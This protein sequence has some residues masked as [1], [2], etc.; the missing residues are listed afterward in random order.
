MSKEACIVTSPT[1]GRRAAGVRRWIQRGALVVALACLPQ[2]VIPAGYD[3]STAAA[4]D[5]RDFPSPPKDKIDKV[6]PFT[7]KKSNAPADKARSAAADTTARLKD[8]RWPEATSASITL[9]ASGTKAVRAGKL[10]ITLKVSAGLG[11]TKNA[12]QAQAAENSASSVAA[13]VELLGH[14]AA[15]KMGLNGVLFTVNPKDQLPGERQLQVSLDYSSFASAYGGSYGSRLKLVQLPACALT[16]PAKAA[17]RSPK[18]LASE[19]STEDQVLTATVPGAAAKT[20]AAGVQPMV[21]AAA[22]AAGSAGGDFSATPLSQ[23][24][25]WDSGGSTGS[26]TWSYPL[27]VPPAT[28]GPEPVVGISYDSSSVDGRTA[29]ENN[30][31]SVVGEGFSIT[32]SYVE[33]KYG[34]C[35]D[36]GQS[37]K[38]DLC[39]KYDNATLVL[40]GKVSEL[41]KAC[42]T[43]TAC[44]ADEKS[45]G[46]S[47]N[48]RLKG[49]DASRVERLTDTT[50]GNGDANGEYWKVTTG[51][52]T[53]YSFGK[54]K[55]E[56]TA[57][58]RV[59]NSVWTAPV[60]GDDTG[61]PC[62]AS[63]FAASYC[64]QAW[65]WNLDYVVDP[66]GNASSYWYA[67]ESN[68]YA[69]DA[70][71]GTGTAYTR[72]G[73]L[74]RIEYGQRTDSLFTKPASQRVSFTYA[75]RC[76]VTDGCTSLTETTKK[77]WPD[78]PF[79]Q[80]CADSKACPLLVSPTFFTRKRLTDVTTSVWK[81]TG[82]GAGTEADFRSVDG[83]HLEQSFPNSG[84]VS[85]PSLWL[86]SIQNT[87]KAGTA[88][89]LPKVTFGGV[90][91][92]NRVDHP[93]DD[94]AP[95]TKWRVRT[96]KSETGSLITVNYSDVQC[97]RGTLMPTSEDKN[98]LRCYPVYWASDGGEPALDWFHKYVVESVFQD[99]PTGGGRT[100][101][102]YNTYGV[103][104]RGAGWGYTDDEGLTKDK[105][106][107]WSQWRGYAK[108]TTT[109]GDASGPRSKKTDL[110]MRGLDGEKEK[111][112]T[113]RDEKTTDS[114]GKV[115]EDSRQYAGFL[116]ESTTYNGDTVVG[117]T[118]NDPWSQ[119][120]ASHAYT[121]GTTE[122][123]F[124]NT[125]TAHKRERQ[126]DGTYRTQSSTTTF[127]TT[128][129]SPISINDA[130][131]DAV[132]GDETC[133]KT[134][135]V[136]NTSAWLINFPSRVESYAVACGTA[137][138]LPEDTLSD[139]TTAYD[140]QPAGTAPTAGDATAVAR[141]KSYTA[142]VPDYQPVA[143]TGYDALGRVASTKDALNRST[144]T[145]YTPD[146]TGYGPVTGSVITD[147]KGYT[148][149]STIDPAWGS[150]TKSVDVNGSTTEYAFD[151]LGRL[152]EVW[153]PDRLRGLGDAASIEYEY[154]VSN[155]DASWVR[156]GTIKA[157]GKTYNSSY[158]IF[159]SLLR[160]RQ[161]Q[162][163][164]P[165]GGRVISETLYDDRGL[166]TISNADVHDETAPA[167][168]LANTLPG[169]VPAST[170]TV[171][172]GAGRVTESI[173][174]VYDQEKWR[175]KTAHL[176]DRVANT[177]ADGGSGTLAIT[178]GRGQ[179]T[180]RREYAGP[181]P[182]G[183]DYT[184]TTYTY[185]PNGQV[186]TMT[187]PDQSVWTYT[188]DLRGRVTEKTDPDSGKTTTS[189][190]D[191]DQVLS[192]T[193]ARNKTVLFDYDVLG[194]TI[195]TWDGIKDNA[196]QL[197]RLTYDT[198]ANG[199]GQPAASVRYVGGVG[200]T[201]S[202]V[203][204][205]QIVKYDSLYRATESKTVLAATDPLV[206]AGAP[207]TYTTNQIFNADGSTQSVRVP[208][209]GG[210]PGET[211]AY[212][213]NALG[214][215][216]SVKGDTDYVRS[217]GYSPLSDVE[218]TL[219]GTSSTAKRMQILNSYEDG[220]RRL[221]NSRSL[222]D[223]NP[224]YTS[225]VDYVYDASG[226]VTSVTDKATS[227]AQCFAYDGHKR[228]TQAWT[229]A[230]S[231][232]CASA[233]AANNLGG[234]A[235][236]WT[237][238]TYNTAGLRDTQTKQAS[239]GNTVT[240]HTYP[241]LSTAGAGQ[242]HTLTSRSTS[243]VTSS[244]TY[245][246]SGNTKT[247]PG[248]KSTQS[249]VWDIE[250]RLAALTEDGK[251]TTYLYSATGDLL[252]RSG[253]TEAVL[254]LGG[255]EVHYD[256]TTKQFTGQRYYSAGSSTAVRT[257]TGLTWK[258]SDHHNTAS[259]VVDA[260]TQK[261][262]RRYTAPF[263][264]T[265]GTKPQAWPDDKAFLGKPQD[266]STQLTHVGARE[267]D[268]DTGRFISVDPIL[269]PD[270]HESLNGYAY[271]NN[272]PV[273]LADPTGLRPDGACG[274]SGT[275]VVGKTKDGDKKY[276][277]WA[278]N[279]GGGWSWG[280]SATNVQ[281]VYSGRQSYTLTVNV[282][283]NRKSGFSGTI[284]LK[285]G[286]K[287]KPQPKI[288]AM[289]T[290]P[291]AGRGIAGD[292]PTAAQADV[293]DCP[294]SDS[295]SKCSFRQSYYRSAMLLQ[296]T[297]GMASGASAAARGKGMRNPGGCT[298]FLAGTL[299]LMADKTV[300]P[301]EKVKVGDKVLASDPES[302]KTH[303]RKITARI[304][305]KKDR[306]YVALTISTPQGLSSLTA[307]SEHP[308]WVE[309]KKLWF[310]AE[311][312]EP[313][314]TLRTASGTTA[315]VASSLH[316]ED[317]K[318]TYNLTVEGVHTYYVLAGQTPVLVH[319]SNCPTASKYEDITSPGAR[320]L[321]KS[322]D[323]GP[324]DFGK[325]LEA[326]GWSRTEKGPNLMYEKDGARYFLR[327]KANSHKGWTADYYNPGSKK[328]DIKI[329]MGED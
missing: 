83:W 119:R 317:R 202:K 65:R 283:Y 118:I 183:D 9:P 135:Y 210:L 314:M 180:E 301:I 177:A 182:E 205:S 312:L 53:Q 77:N 260:T 61:E 277:T 122:A 325:N 102:T 238:W 255:Q 8:T 143:T 155:A 25:S 197:T 281:E 97:V 249:L 63:T 117:T 18:D 157:D 187:G 250:G 280:W 258:V 60:F 62:N 132:S 138:Q 94:I 298:C 42:A 173:F 319:N 156:T 219:L 10:P 12:P 191:A 140:S 26:F 82:T 305:T 126:P 213:H 295:A 310:K 21:F 27:R 79:D 268:T 49:D 113:P 101:E 87:G 329:R 211:V 37:G 287:P 149:T 19:N 163:P 131:D 263:G 35:K 110:F 130:G 253:P 265:R 324:V 228:L 136:R 59:T 108:V 43:D 166:A 105:H 261:L 245:D 125:A 40:N 294:A 76:V 127:D 34:S 289:G 203:Y 206:L 322:T 243:G 174:R 286:P 299:V 11:K 123:W 46:A 309:S 158:E 134:T 201:G 273:T 147:P 296:V 15:Q 248:P 64:T 196:H 304:T 239:A 144:T 142:G 2:V 129:G 133:T 267:Y 230:G 223:T 235:P 161:N 320:M 233:P 313:G 297:L 120:T 234:P 215:V 326:N 193:D 276:E 71:T 152:T 109:V 112:G 200:Q 150:V 164:S 246:E 256:T 241:K 72:G 188:Y 106:R 32:E 67:K 75:E 224:G 17:C 254:Y 194:R 293:P 171:I 45:Q 270:D 54:H 292:G 111:D 315:K 141:V 154:S 226:N 184:K 179:T 3:T 168:A 96:I 115:L 100:I 39:W 272:T 169:S 327:G 266:T 95:F 29:S 244:Y 85:Q 229:P 227:D 50:L 208:A 220:T 162:S 1:R 271:A 13:K 288:W 269:A 146:S 41:V 189:Y 116:R 58:S 291:D 323:V 114:T 279:G 176:G 186:K 242:P 316:Y 98:D 16:T 232:T 308:F 80:I 55:L 231:S 192:T 88:I 247:R 99:D 214:M 104:D 236:Y 36:D 73:Y 47:T 259:L 178:N 90:Q 204:S 31:T 185:W 165:A 300:K 218:E 190:D 30:Q 4:A 23:S 33:R 172:D 240:T 275:C 81:G 121:W 278:Y 148:V 237:S 48:W 22:A 6:L 159:D 137:P 93:N 212:G 160:S 44:R 216:T 302:G 257:N 282:S 20:A 74:Q 57:G 124:V 328:A 7:K 24:A 262:T 28:A 318:Q 92:S 175:T 103:N 38:G 14:N 284:S 290:G 225:D 207:S 221:K 66:H 51:D 222:D 285:K 139:T 321:N 170:E 198:V 145:T 181:K 274:G 167:G 209:A 311:D 217:V 70:T 199:K 86:E 84:D 91:K 107:T 69:K 5:R 52:G 303:A 252:I 153:Q 56:S 68:N 151:A 78:V 89:S 195:G 128:Y 264:E 306:G 251:T 307:T